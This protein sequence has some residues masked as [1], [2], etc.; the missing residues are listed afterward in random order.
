MAAQRRLSNTDMRPKT[1]A[2][3][4]LRDKPNRAMRCAGKPVTS[5]PCKRTLP[6]EGG[7]RPDITLN[8]LD[9]PAPLGPIKAWNS[10]MG[11]RRLTPS[12]T[13]TSP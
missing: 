6:V 13:W 4:K 8:R 11:T 3:W 5:R 10:P 2:T 12:S 9:L 1:L 7:V